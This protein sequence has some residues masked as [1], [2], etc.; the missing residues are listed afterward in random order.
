[1]VAAPEYPPP[2]PDPLR[3]QGR[4]GKRPERLSAGEA[5]RAA[6][7][8]QGFAAS[9]P[10]AV[11]ATDLKRL[12]R[13]LGV[14][15]IDSVNVL[16]R[17][18]YLPA[19]SR[20]GHYDRALLDRAAY[21]GKRRHLFEYWGHEASFLPVECW[22]LFR[23]R[24]EEAEN[25]ERIWAHVDDARRNEP[26]LIERVLGEVRDRGPIAASDLEDGTDRTGPWW[27]WSRGKRVLEYL[28][29]AGRL[30]TATRRNFERVY[31]L[32]E[33]VLPRAALAAPVPD[34]ATALR[35][36]LEMAARALGVATEPDLRDYFRLRPQDSKPRVAELVED[37]TLLPVTV[38]GWEQPA[39]LHKDARIPRRVEAQA[40][41]SPFDSLIWERDRTERIWGFRYR[42]EIYT[43]AA[44]RLH[45]YY[46]LP[47]LLGDR[48]VGRVDLKSDR[49]A[50]ALRVA[51]AH[52]E[53]G[54]DPASFI[55]ALA[56]NLR[57]MAAWL[58]L[59]RIEV[60]SKG[61]LAPALRGHL[62][63]TV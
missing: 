57:K 27:G 10:D 40:L 14:V 3:P 51:A 55:P 4:S 23:W 33:R 9:G 52:A 6:L 22:P 15:Q 63:A 50:G 28:F 35:T 44:R 36:L 45:G 31:D 54:E 58:G 21:D 61:E 46:V 1:M 41:L 8:A 13:R 42:I 37:G 34:K 43:P 60:A 7:A 12:T 5:R 20:L 29:W 17:S 49:A 25:G 62:S 59:E 56:G 48:L 53:P 32:P 38:K 2:H 39:Y 19:F 26:G 30:T 24:M 47:F 11:A 16:V 18:H